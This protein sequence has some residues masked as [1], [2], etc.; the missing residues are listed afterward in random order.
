MLDC[1]MSI[2]RYLGQAK[3]DIINLINVLLGLTDLLNVY[4]FQ[5]VKI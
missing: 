1:G 3:T 4:S 2:K 5:I